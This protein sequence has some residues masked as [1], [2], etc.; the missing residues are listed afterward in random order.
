MALGKQPIHK[1]FKLSCTGLVLGA[2]LLIQTS[3][4]AS[5]IAAGGVGLRPALTNP[6]YQHENSWFIYEIDAKKTK[7]VDDAVLVLN[8]SQETLN[9]RLDAVDAY[10]TDNGGFALLDGKAENENLGSWIT[11]EETEV[12]VAPGERR[13]VNF[14]INIPENPEVGDHI[15]GI[16]AQKITDKA[17]ATYRSGGATVTVVTRVGARVY[18]TIKG[19]IQRGFAVKKRY[20]RGAGKEIFFGFTAKNK[21]NIRTDLFFDAKIYGLFGLY[22]KK[23]GLSIGQIFPNKEISR[24]IPWQGKERPLFG[25]Y[26]AI[27]KVY[28]VYEPMSHTANIPPAPAPVTLWAFTFFIPYT[29]TLIV[30]ILLFLIW[31]TR[32]ALV[33]RRMATLARQP[34][35]IYKVKKGDY[36]VDV[37]DEY[38]VSWKLLARLNGLKPPYSLRKVPTIYIPDARGLRRDIP[39]IG[40]WA[41]MARPAT[42]L[43]GLFKRKQRKLK[44]GERIIIVDKGDKIRDIEKFTGMAWEDI[45]V[46]NRL[47]PSFHL[48]AGIQLVVPWAKKRLPKK[49]TRRR[50]K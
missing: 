33:W 43:L 1:L 49:A 34:V 18:L 28:D 50:R 38:G 36:L 12:T 3:V 8:T 31:F 19:D 41:H 11:L 16:I 10:L 45:L 6:E 24:E 7:T 44:E 15:G 14:K 13:L 35:V 32:Q 21:G 22:D 4:P 30:I 47:R 39:L 27:M 46:Y 26:L 20:F 17:D 40:F 25:P 9:V 5:A 29:Q 48:R 42:G 37:A 23:E 2:I